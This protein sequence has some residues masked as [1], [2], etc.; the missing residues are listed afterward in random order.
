MTED[1]EITTIQVAI[2]LTGLE[3]SATYFKVSGWWVWAGPGDRP[4][5]VVAT[6]GGPSEVEAYRN[7]LARLEAQRD[8]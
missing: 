8:G 4:G 6:G 5:V 7:L 2:S 1:E 3:V